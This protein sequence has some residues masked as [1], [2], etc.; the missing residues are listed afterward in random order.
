MGFF[1]IALADIVEHRLDAPEGQALSAEHHSTF[2]LSHLN[3][4]FL[5]PNIFS[6]KIY[7]GLKE[8]YQKSDWIKV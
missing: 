4:L 2:Q 3:N 8:S 6:D 1:S 5:M 7:K